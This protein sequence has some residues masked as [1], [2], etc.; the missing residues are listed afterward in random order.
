V[1]AAVAPVT[2]VA[3]ADERPAARDRRARGLDEVRQR[4]ARDGDVEGDRLAF[5]PEALGNAVPDRPELRRIPREDVRD[6]A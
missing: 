3:E 5:L 4:R 1:D 6:P 2:V